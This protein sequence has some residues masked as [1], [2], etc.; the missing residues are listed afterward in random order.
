[1]KARKILARTGMMILLASLGYT[2]FLLATRTT[3]LHG[4]YGGSAG[5]CVG[6]LQAYQPDMILGDSQVLTLT[7]DYGEHWT[8]M[9]L[10][11]AR[12]CH[13]QAELSAP[14]FEV[15]PQE[16]QEI[17]LS[18]GEK[19]SLSWTITPTRVGGHTVEVLNQENQLTLSITVVKRAAIYELTGLTPQQVTDGAG[20]V[21]GLVLILPWL[22]TAWRQ[23]ENVFD[24][25]SP[26]RDLFNI[27]ILVFAGTVAWLFFGFPSGYFP[28]FLLLCPSSLATYFISWL[29]GR[30]AKGD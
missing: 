16:Q 18:P 8:N 28:P 3:T 29:L 6:I 11:P 30:T 15:S 24:A 25:L 14:A 4:F 27:S 7:A 19:A 21:L 26:Q 13:F 9:R 2:W 20:Y 1:M 12:P 17:D 5:P 22:Y 23:H 10:S